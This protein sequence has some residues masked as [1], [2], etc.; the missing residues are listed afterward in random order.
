MAMAP[1]LIPT[2]RGCR[3]E[4]YLRSQNLNQ[5]ASK[6]TIKEWPL[7]FLWPDFAKA[8]VCS[9]FTF[10]KILTENFMSGK[11]KTS[12]NDYWIT[13][14]PIASRVTSREKTV[15]G[16]SFGKSHTNLAVPRCSAN[17]KSSA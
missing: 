10:S 1:L 16:N 13:I 14:A 6:V 17:G 5:S 9:G 15:L 12:P 3:F 7:V 2:S 11:A 8:F 4:S